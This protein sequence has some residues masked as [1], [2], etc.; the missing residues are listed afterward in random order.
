MSTPAPFRT[1][2]T[3]EPPRICVFAMAG[4]LDPIATEGLEAELDALLRDGERHFVLD[5]T[6][7]TY[8]GSLGL[9]AFIRLAARL[10]GN[11]DVRIFGMT[12]AVREL[13]ELTKLTNLFQIYPTKQDA[14]DASRSA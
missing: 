10:K 13:F 5:L 12:P 6:G 9:R 2:S 1:S 3:I 4:K 11:G 8:V 7:L 14:L